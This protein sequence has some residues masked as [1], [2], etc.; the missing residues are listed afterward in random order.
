MDALSQMH[1]VPDSGGTLRAGARRGQLS[2]LVRPLLQLRPVSLAG[3][4]S[5]HRYCP[6]VDG[7]GTYR[8]R[9]MCGRGLYQPGD[10]PQQERV[11]PDLRPRSVQLGTGTKPKKHAATAHPT[12]GR[13]VGKKP[14]IADLAAAYHRVRPATGN[15]R[16]T[17]LH[18]L[19]QGQIY[20][21]GRHVRKMPAC[22]PTTR[23]MWPMRCYRSAIRAGNLHRLRGEQHGRK[24]AG[25]W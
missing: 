16:Q 5:D 2:R 1:R 4:G 20:P 17:P 25:G 11:L 13:P 14:V 7:A 22:Q 12:A 19:R 24:L 10:E 6:G 18:L 23:A 21:E 8:S 3:S 9:Q 15:R